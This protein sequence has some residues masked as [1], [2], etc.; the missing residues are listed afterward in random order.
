[1]DAYTLIKYLHVVAAITA[2]GFNLSYG[3]WLGLTAGAPEQRLHVLR[4]IKLL[5]DR[6]ANPAYVV[7]LLTGLAMVGVGSLS[8]TTTWIAVALAL[9]VVLVVLGLGVFSRALSGQIRALEA[10]EGGTESYAALSRR[11]T[12][13]GALLVL[14]ALVIVFLMV[15]KPTV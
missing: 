14:I 5:D 13:S 3:V 4:G 6:F 12:V 15:T 8:F 7:L 1:M 10:G 2:V 11:T 9:Y